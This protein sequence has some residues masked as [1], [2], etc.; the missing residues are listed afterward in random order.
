MSLA[1]VGMVLLIGLLGEAGR[2]LLGDNFHVVL[3]GQIYRTAQRSPDQLEQLVRQLGIRSVVN[4]RGAS[5]SPWYLDQCRRIQQLG[6]NQFDVSMSASRLPPA[7]EMRRL[8]DI[9]DHA[10]YPICFHCRRGADRTGVASA[11]AR[12]LQPGSTF[13]EGRCQLHWR[14]GHVPYGSL[15]SMD[16]LLDLYKEWLDRKAQ[17]HDAGL[18]RHWLQHE[19]RGSCD[20]AVEK[21][22]WLPPAPHTSASQEPPRIVCEIPIALEVR[23]RNTGPTTWNVTTHSRAGFHL[24]YRVWD[25]KGKVALE[26]RWCAREVR[27]AP[28]EIL[29]ETVVVPGELTPGRYRIMVDMVEE[30][31]AWF[32]QTGTEPME[33]E[34][35][36]CE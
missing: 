35:D 19:Y 33:M 30:N 5:T 16:E 6:V 27:I 22:A 13:A 17:Q 28:G 10:E 9:I 29:A 7:Q 8:V 23:L 20:Y 21:F 2:V 14:F 32:Y 1:A 24:S 25:S 18:F 11:I 12:L 15:K 36:V 4:L 26:G 3:S 31:R 34:L